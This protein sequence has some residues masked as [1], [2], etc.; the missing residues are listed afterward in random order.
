[1]EYII[2][3]Q[4][5]PSGVPGLFHIAESAANVIGITTHNKSI[6]VGSYLADYLFN[7]ILGGGEPL[8]WLC[9]AA[10]HVAREVRDC[11]DG[12]GHIDRVVLLD[13]HGEYDELSPIDIEAVQNN[14]EGMNEAIRHLF[15]LAADISEGSEKN[16]LEES[17]IGIA[18]EAREGQLRWM[19][20][21]RERTK[22]RTSY[23]TFFADKVAAKKS[24]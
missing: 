18:Q 14:V 19:T 13:R 23:L 20:E 4:P 9:A 21:F 12:V 17:I 3:I 22:R 16:G 10:V 5:L 8:A 2:A 6:G 15:S 11:I 24:G 1:M 7:L